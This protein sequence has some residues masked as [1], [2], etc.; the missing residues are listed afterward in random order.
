[1]MF[2]SRPSK[3]VC[4]LLDELRLEAG[5]AVA[6]DVELDLPALTLRL[7]RSAVT[8]VAGVVAGRIMLLVA[9]VVGEFAIKGALDQCFGELL[10]KPV[11]AK[12]VFRLL[13]VLQQFIQEFRSDRWH[14]LL[15]RNR[16]V[17]YRHLHR[18]FITSPS[19]Y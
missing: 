12:Q 17:D 14:N 16:T 11:L 3:R 18:L 9:K 5:V 6:R 1:M 8:R 10:K 13:V 19:G 7:R 2:S 4:P 15:L